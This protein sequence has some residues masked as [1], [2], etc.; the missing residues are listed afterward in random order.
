MP[1][2]R[3]IKPLVC[4][5]CLLAVPAATAKAPRAKPSGEPVAIWKVT[6]LGLDKQVVRQIQRGLARAFRRNPDW[7]LL[8]QRTLRA[9]LTKAGLDPRASLEQAAPASQAAYLL[10]GTMA[11]LG[12]EVSLDLKLHAGADGREIRRV[13]VTLPA[14]PQAQ[15]AVLDEALLRL[16]SPQRWVGGLALEVSEAGAQVFFDGQPVA[17]TPM[18]KPLTGLAPGKHILMIRKEGFGEFSKFVAIRYGQVAR[19]KVD[20]ASATVVGLLYEEERAA[21]SPAPAPPPAALTAPAPAPAGMN[22]Q[23]ITGWTVFGVGAAATAVGGLLAWHAAELEDDVERGWWTP[24][25]EDILADKLKQGRD[26]TDMSNLMF[27]TGGGLAAVSIGFLVWGYLAGDDSTP[28]AAG[29]DPVG[30]APVALPGGAGVS[31]SSRF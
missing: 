17:R 13:S 21:P 18:A 14:Q 23:Q 12:D 27:I 2:G 29:P 6:A 25:N 30:I 15:A 3:W 16:L 20:L 10:Q 22:W 7:R 24:A 4:A 28:A 9:R 31:F 19:I 5:A 8:S 26:A 11:G 1:S